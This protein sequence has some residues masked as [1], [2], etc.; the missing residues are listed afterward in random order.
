LFS[1][2]DQPHITVAEA[3]ADN[4]SALKFN[5]QLAGDLLVE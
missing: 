4:F 3:F 1:V 5:R 2:A